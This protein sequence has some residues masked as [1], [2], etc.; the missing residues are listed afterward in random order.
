MVLVAAD[1]E[2]TALKAL[3]L[4]DV[5]YEVLPALDDPREAMKED[6]VQIHE[7]HPSADRGNI[8]TEVNLESGDAEKYCAGWGPYD[9]RTGDAQEPGTGS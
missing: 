8:L 1:S 6:A 5:D 4:I 2:E 3:E 7:E 9:F